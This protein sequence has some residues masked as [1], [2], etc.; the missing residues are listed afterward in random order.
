MVQ[1]TSYLGA[2]DLTRRRKHS[3]GQRLS[4]AHRPRE[5]RAGAVGLGEA[6]VPP[7]PALLEGRAAGQERGTRPSMATSSPQIQGGVGGT[8][9]SSIC[10]QSPG[11]QSASRRQA[12]SCSPLR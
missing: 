12:L 4:S 11:T 3:S 10:L 9:S 7:I 1:E 8:S 6:S 2:C 5:R